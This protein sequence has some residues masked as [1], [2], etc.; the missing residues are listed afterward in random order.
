MATSGFSHS[1]LTRRA[2]VGSSL[3]GA[4][5]LPLAAFGQGGRGASSHGVAAAAARQDA[6]TALATWKT[7]LLT[8]PDELRL[9][10]PGA[11]AAAEIEEIVGFLAAPT[12]EMTAAIRKWGAQP[13]TIPWTATANEAFSEFRVNGMRQSRNYALVH[14]AMHDAAVAAWDAQLAY[15]RPSP[16]AS[17]GR[18]VPGAGITPA[19]PSFVSEHA[20]IAAAA[21]TVLAY[22]LPD[23]APGRFDD[24]AQEAAMSRVWAGAA[25]LS[26][27]EAGLALGK[28]IS[29]LAVERGRGDGSDAVFDRGEMPSGPGFWVPTLPG[30]VADPVEAL[31][32]TWRL[33]ILESGDQLRP[34]P[35]PVY[36]SPAWRSELL[37][38]QQI[39]RSRTLAQTSDAIWWQQNAL[40]KVFLDWTNELL[41]RHGLTT[42]RAARVLAYQSVS[43]A[44]S[45]VAV[46]E[47]KYHWWTSRPI[48][49]DPEIVKAF[50]TPPYPA[51]PSGYSALAGA[52][53]QSAG[54][55]FSDAAGELDQLAW[56]AACSRALA[57]IHYPIDNEVGMMMGR[58]VARL[59]AVRAM[60]EGALPA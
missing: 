21:A 29:E 41:M 48:T 9:A 58:Q 30:L 38:A 53:A 22:L 39:S 37:A 49:E 34:A 4:A 25:F 50:A 36:D 46:W 54:L 2:V 59:A 20:A 56:R 16:A 51:Y 40:Y 55:F 23:A 52:M 3:T 6:T 28:A 60:E 24:L 27:V 1:R 11:P 44:D 18:I 8:S 12:A 15:T 33:W 43:M 45:L 17:D 10:A 57:G 42:P 5:L 19:A 47:A 26:D 35:P 13:A 32:G 31:G 7:W 14:T